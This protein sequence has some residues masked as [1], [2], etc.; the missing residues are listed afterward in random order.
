MNFPPHHAIFKNLPKIDDSDSDGGSNATEKL[1]QRAY[2]RT[3]ENI[4]K[5]KETRA[6]VS[7][8]INNLVALEYQK[9]EAERKISYSLPNED[10][11]LGLNKELNFYMPNN[12]KETENFEK[13]VQQELHYALYCHEDYLTCSNRIDFSEE[14]ENKESAKDSSKGFYEKHFQC[15]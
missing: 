12:K 3:K 11:Y 4:E 6:E 9:E 7:G 15:S 1:I 14:M 5:S 8:L 2:K 10:E 13:K